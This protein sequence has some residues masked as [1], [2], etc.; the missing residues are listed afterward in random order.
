MN[1]SIYSGELT[2][3]KNALMEALL[4]EHVPDWEK[5]YEEKMQTSAAP[6]WDAA[7]KMATRMRDR[8]LPPPG[9]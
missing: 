7:Q 9:V 5:L 6:A 3:L 2:S 8:L 4:N 1:F